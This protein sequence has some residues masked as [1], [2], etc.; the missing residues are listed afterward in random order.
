MAAIVAGF[1]V[2]HSP[3]APE[4]VRLSGGDHPVARLYDRVAAGIA[5][6]RPDAL[7]IF[8]SDHFSTFFLDNWPIF[9]IGIADRIAGPNDGTVMPRYEL[10]GHAALA[11]HIRRHAIA[12]GFDV[13]LV[14]DFEVDHSVLVPLHFMPPT[15]RLPIVPI[16]INGFV[17]PLPTAE[18]CHAFGQI[19]RAAVDSFPE[20]L[21]VAVLASG[22]ASLEVGGP[23]VAP[24]R[25]Q[26]VPDP[27]W[28]EHVAAL[29]RAG[30]HRQLVAEA[31]FERLQKAG[32]I[33]GELLNWIALIGALGERRAD[34]VISQR[35]EG[36]AYAVWSEAPA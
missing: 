1:G 12:A 32:N 31:T 30:R 4:Q 11:T 10:P 29:I 13:A 17:P 5:A 19:V 22:Q 8:D 28:A 27:D 25:R 3:H 24:G 20:P 18:R 15:H 33:G 21:R 9:A 36:D 26:G 23:K 2:P 7:V 35:S 6:A 34:W 14:Q 16:F